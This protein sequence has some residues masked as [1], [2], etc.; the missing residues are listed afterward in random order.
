MALLIAAVAL[1]VTHP[2]M[3]CGFVGGFWTVLIVVWIN[4]SVANTHGQINRWIAFPA[5][6]LLP[7]PL[8]VVC[9]HPAFLVWSAVPAVAVALD[10]PFMLRA[11]NAVGF[12][13]HNSGMQLSWCC[14]PGRAGKL[15][16]NVC[17]ASIQSTRPPASKKH[18]SWAYVMIC[19]LLAGVVGLIVLSVKTLD[20]LQL[21]A[22]Y[23]LPMHSPWIPEEIQAK[24]AARA[25]FELSGTASVVIAL[26]HMT[27]GVFMIHWVRVRAQN[28]EEFDAIVARPLETARAQKQHDELTAAV[29]P[30]APSFRRRL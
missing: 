4:A 5:M 1:S 26:F 23:I 9:G 6:F 30:G 11:I 12:F 18:R 8:L 14:W 20:W 25:W 2:L 16:W 21:P 3:A 19:C 29:P 10:I 22:G 13:R 27:H 7:I 28:P 17:V 15:L 24:S